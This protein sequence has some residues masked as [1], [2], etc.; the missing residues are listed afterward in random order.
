MILADATIR[1]YIEKGIIGIDPYESKNVE[2]ASVDLRLGS[3]FLIP[4]DFNTPYLTLDDEVKYRKDDGDNMVILPGRFVLGTT[5]ESVRLP[6]NIAARVEGRSSIG[7]RGLFIQN[8]GWV[9]P[10]FEGQITLELYN[11]NNFPLKIKSGKRICQIVFQQMDR[12]AEE[13]YHGKYQGQRN[14]TGSL[15][16]KDWEIK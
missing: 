6:A 7:R 16:H 14:T 13:P 5:L 2:S 10:G 12:E 9:D 1:D 4:D 3:G 11:A 15:A 8:A